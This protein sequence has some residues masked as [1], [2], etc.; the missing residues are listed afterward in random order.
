MEGT[1]GLGMVYGGVVVS[2]SLIV[3]LTHS[4]SSLSDSEK[5]MTMITF[6]RSLF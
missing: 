5:N 6:L 4:E 3:E 2:I 1:V